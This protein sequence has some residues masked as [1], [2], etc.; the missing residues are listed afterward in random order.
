MDWI[1]ENVDYLKNRRSP[2]VDAEAE[3]ERALELIRNFYPIGN[4]FIYA[5]SYLSDR[6]I[7]LSDG[8][9]DMLGYSRED[10]NNLDF[11]YDRIHPDDLEYVKNLTIHAIRAFSGKNRLEPMSQVFHIIY[12]I[13]RKD[14]KYIKVQ[15]QS[16]MLTKD[17]R[18]D[19]L[20]SFGIYTD[21]SQLSNSDD[22]L[23]YM[24]GP[25]IPDYRFTH[26]TEKPQPGFTKREREIINLMAEGYSSG[27]IGRKLFISKETVSTHRRNILQKTG[28]RNSS[29]L[30]AYVFKNGY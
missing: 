17:A 25:D 27:E 28:V 13:R 20:T 10:A 3:H 30:M 24:S 19:M 14:G 6:I 29:G 23:A 2:V 9:E 22:V 8:I 26:P 4:Q 7:Y 16:G 12:R 21:V 5:M 11:L 1:K 18:H 15:R